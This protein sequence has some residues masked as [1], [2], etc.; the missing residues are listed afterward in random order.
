MKLIEVLPNWSYYFG[1]TV[2]CYLSPTRV[3]NKL[4]SEV[5]KHH[6]KIAPLG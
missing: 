3:F 2:L 1:H 6:W 4:A 5:S